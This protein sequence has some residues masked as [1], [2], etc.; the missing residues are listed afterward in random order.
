MYFISKYDFIEFICKIKNHEPS[1]EAMKK[2]DTEQ[3]IITK[4]QRCTFDILIEQDPN[5]KNNCLV[6]DID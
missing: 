3:S 5:D 2:L 4:C 6:S 1:I